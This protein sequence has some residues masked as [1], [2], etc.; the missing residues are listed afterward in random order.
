ML[1]PLLLSLV[2]PAHAL[3]QTQAGPL[4]TLAAGGSLTG[5][6]VQPSAAGQL[7][8]GAWFG[9]YDDAYSFGRYWAVVQTTRVDLLSARGDT[10]VAPMLE[11]RRG[12]DILVANVA[13]F[14]AGGPALVVADGTTLGGTAR[15]GVD[16][17]WRRT[18]FWGLTVRLEGGVDVLDGAVQPTAAV[19]VGAGFARPARPMDKPSGR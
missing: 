14:V 5:A 16:A 18:R 4:F 10:T 12:L 15:A 8:F 9:T 3:T 19:L 2:A 6:P 17:K 11:L 7:S 13:G 1:V